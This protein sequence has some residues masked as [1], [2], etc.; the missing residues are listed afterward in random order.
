MK[1][2]KFLLVLI[3]SVAISGAF[4]SLLA[5]S[6]N[7]HQGKSATVR[8]YV[9]AARTISAGE[10]L[11]SQDLKIVEWPDLA[12]LQGSFTSPSQVLGRTVLYPVAENQP[13]MDRYLAANGAGIGLAAKVPDGMRAISVRSDD[14]VGVGGFLEPGSQVDVLVTYRPSSAS[15]PYTITALQD[16]RVAAVGQRIE[17]EPAGKPESVTVV[18]L[19]VSPE[20]AQEAVL[21]STQGSVHF[22]LR[23][24]ADRGQ[25]T[26]TPVSLSMLGGHELQPPA[27]PVT[28]PKIRTASLAIA[29]ASPE[30]VTVLDGSDDQPKQGADKP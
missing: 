21:A 6:L 1:V 7:N 8:K 25:S 23:N 18:T 17:P 27:P 3:A 9:A 11:R 22:I 20:Q 4:T 12:P 2:K 10:V 19:F 26:T 16:V 13:V 30:I 24:G 14:V 28:Q 29:H 5:R 15:E